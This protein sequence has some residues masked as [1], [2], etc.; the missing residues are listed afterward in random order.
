M[1]Y[2]NCEI[3]R[4]SAG[5]DNEHSNNLP[6]YESIE[7]VKYGKHKGRLW[8]QIDLKNYL[9][10]NN[11]SG[12]FLT[13]EISLLYP[14]GIA[15]IHDVSY[16]ANPSFFSSTNKKIS[17][18][19][20]CINYSFITKCC[21]NILTVSNFSKSEII[22]YY[23]VQDNR[24][25][26]IYNSWQHMRKIIEDHSIIEKNDWLK[27]KEYYFSMSTIAPNK[28]FE[29][30]L[31]AAKQNPLY[32][33]AIAGGGK[34]KDVAETMGYA[35]LSNV[36]YLGY[37]SDE[38]AKALMHHCK[39]FLF[40]T[41]YEG[42]GIPPLEAIACGCEQII[43]SDIPCMHEIYGD[44]AKYINPTNYN[45]ID[46]PEDSKHIDISELLNK[47]SWKESARKVLSVINSE[48]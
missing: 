14:K 1:D 45:N 6:K 47:Y 46:L 19:W 33:F 43:V 34:L 28:N 10:K 36:H 24:I 25:S 4:K 42:F 3:K 35:S 30:V 27:E 37:V 11:K 15:C 21:S 22:K 2:V 38:E 48:M 12:I 7:I 39:A 13:N 20:H 41:L 29:W 23:N 40:P 26:V 17:R 8:E 5:V 18:L 44:Y 16:R 32:E 9:K 31:S